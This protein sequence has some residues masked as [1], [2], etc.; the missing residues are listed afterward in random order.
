MTQEGT[1][2]GCLGDDDRTGKVQSLVGLVV[3]DAGLALLVE[4][5]L[6][7]IEEGC[8]S[9]WWTPLYTGGEIGIFAES[10][11]GWGGAVLL[12]KEF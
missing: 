12:L 2:E 6:N 7:S 5:V 3:G 4:A 1:V 11:G 10:Q 9:S 8:D